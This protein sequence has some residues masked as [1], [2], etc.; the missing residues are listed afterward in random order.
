[1]CLIADCVLKL[2]L[3]PGASPEGAHEMPDVRHGLLVW[4]GMFYELELT[5]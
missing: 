2:I 5:S 4:A 3:L 1:M